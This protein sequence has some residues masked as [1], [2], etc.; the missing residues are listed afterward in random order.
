MTWVDRS[1]SQA[2]TI[3]VTARLASSS[4][5]ARSNNARRRTTGIGV[6]H[7][8]QWSG[9]APLLR[10]LIDLGEDAIVQARWRPRWRDRAKVAFQRGVGEASLA[11]ASTPIASSNARRA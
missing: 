9:Q 3:P 4:A 11:H 6:R 7:A 5:A 8:R 2:P 1:S 10:R